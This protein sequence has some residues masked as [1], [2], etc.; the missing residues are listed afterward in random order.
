MTRSQQNSSSVTVGLAVAAGL[1]ILLVTAIAAQAQ[2]FQVLHN[3]TGGRDGANP[4]DG[5]T[6]DRNGNLYGTASAGGDQVYGCE[7]FYRTTGCGAVFELAR[8]GSGWILR[9]LYDF[10][11]GTDAYPTFGVVFGPDGAL[12]GLTAGTS[13]SC[14]NEY[15]CG[16]VFRLTPPPTFCA[17]FTCNW[18]ETVLHQFPGQPDGSSPASRVLFDPAGN[19]YGVTFFGGLYNEGVAYELSPGRG[20]WTENALY[21]FNPNLGVGT[22]LP[23]GPLVLDPSGNLYG[24]A[25]CNEIGGCYSTVW[26]LQHSQSGWDLNNIFNFNGN[27]GY[28]LDG[29]ISDA[30]GNLYGFSDGGLGNGSENAFE[31]SPSNGGWNYTLVNDLGSEGN[32]SGPAM[33]S[34]GNL[35]GS[36]VIYGYGTLFKLTRSGN[37]WAYS[38]L[39]TF[40][41]SDGEFPVGTLTVDS[42][43][44]LYGTTIEGGAYG[45]GVIWEITP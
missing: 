31:L 29:V 8:S 36:N 27:N 33:D 37:T 41:G 4:L 12:Y 21:S 9:P 45:Y 44:N 35:Y 17:S 11:G 26:Q 32:L 1:C 16:G 24:T 18:Q 34:A 25:Y 43:G 22:S 3:F 14:S 39:H 10:Q 20:G 19:L 28:E 38:L 30:S 15:G 42:S 6:I 13:A 2:T 23:V 40:S 7:N 5:V